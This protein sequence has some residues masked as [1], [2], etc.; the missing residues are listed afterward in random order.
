[1]TD[2]SY[3]Q[4]L[5]IIY[6]EVTNKCNNTCKYCYAIQRYNRASIMSFE[7][8]KE[9]I[10]L[11]ALYSKSNHIS[12]IFHGGEPLLA[13]TE[14][15][16]QCIQYANAHFLAANK[17]V[18]YGI[19]SNLI[20]LDDDMIRIMRDNDI[21]VSTSI[22][23]PQELH[24]EARAGWRKTIDHFKR[25]KAAGIQANFITVC[26]HHNKGHIRELFQFAK[27]L[28]AKSIQ[29]NIASSPQI[30]NPQ[31]PYPPLSSDEILSVF[32]DTLSYMTQ[33]GVMEKNMARMIRYFLND[34]DERMKLLRCDSP[35]CHAGVNML[36]FTPDGTIYPCSPAV[37][38]TLVGEDFSLGTISKPLHKK[39][40]Q[41]SL[42]RFHAKA[43]KYTQEC[44]KCE[45]A[46]I[47]DFGCPAFDRIDPVTAENHCI[48]TKALYQ[49]FEKMT[50]EELKSIINI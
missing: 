19:Q 7:I 22:D 32:K 27:E 43:N 12:I 29:L 2:Y 49:L 24:D 41:E 47:C 6:I 39:P 44:T 15:F 46:R 31:S 1:M 20:L 4:Q 16:E 42:A 5:S 17:T 23:G 33:F 34:S 3:L 36:V 38:L 48:A 30:I 18:D 35:F 50:Q 25:I 11:V 45:A 37:P 14:F 8:F 13:H 10:D 21:I 40:Y 28:G 26:S 9:I